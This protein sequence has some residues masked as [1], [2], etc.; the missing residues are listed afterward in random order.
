MEKPS[1]IQRDSRLGSVRATAEINEKR[2][3]KAKVK[4]DQLTRSLDYTWDEKKMVK[5]R[6][7]LN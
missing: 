5:R 7:R 2:G 1:D 6:V 4:V 3:G